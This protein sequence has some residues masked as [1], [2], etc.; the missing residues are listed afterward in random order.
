MTSGAGKGAF[1]CTKPIQ[2]DVVVDGNVQK[3][4]TF[5]GLK[6][7]ILNVFPEFMILPL[8]FMYIQYSPEQCASPLIPQPHR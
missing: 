2:V 3:V 5:F 6:F 4:V 8:W 7:R 1:T